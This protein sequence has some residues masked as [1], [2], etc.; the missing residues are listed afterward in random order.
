MGFEWLI[1]AIKRQL[2]GFWIEL[3]VW[4]LGFFLTCESIPFELGFCLASSRPAGLMN[5]EDVLG[6]IKRCG[7]ALQG[8]SQRE[9]GNVSKKIR[10]VRK[11]MEEIDGC[12]PSEEI[13]QERKMVCKELDKLL[14]M[15]ETMWKQRSRVDNLKG[16][17][18]NTKYFHM[19]ATGRKRRNMIRGVRKE[20]GEWVCEHDKIT[21]AAT[22]YFTCLFTSTLLM[23]LSRASM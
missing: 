16:G 22:E 12:V 6:K 21:K 1:L 7:V 8:W 20:N 23:R 2:L 3:L 4:I 9:F 11:S 10:S 13:V 18:Q 17:D 15:E 5:G 19:K 14:G